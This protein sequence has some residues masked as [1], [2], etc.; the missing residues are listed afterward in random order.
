MTPTR[1]RAE[2]ICQILADIDF[3]DGRGDRHW[4]LRIKSKLAEL[5]AQF[6][7]DTCAS[8][9]P[10]QC[11]REWLYDIVWFRTAEGRLHEIGLVAESEWSINFDYIRYDFEKLLVATS[12]L[13]LMIFQ[14]HEGQLEDYFTRLEQGVR[15]FKQQQSDH[16]YVLAA[17]LIGSEEFRHHFI[18][19]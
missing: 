5:G 7:F 12:P 3:S 6:H 4:T 8:G 17:F 2:A 18:E 16:T 14:C 11:E 15:A 1:Q 10:D 19:T 13:K 9:L